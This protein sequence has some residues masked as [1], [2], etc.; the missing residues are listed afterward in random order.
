V[1][2]KEKKESKAYHLVDVETPVVYGRGSFME[3]KSCTRIGRREK[4]FTRKKPH[5]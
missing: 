4:L 5:H 3:E 2:E 1:C